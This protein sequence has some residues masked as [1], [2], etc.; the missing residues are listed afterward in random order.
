MLSVVDIHKRFGEVQALDGCSL[1]VARGRMLGFLGPNGA[2]KTTVMRAVFGLVEPDAARCSGTGG[3]SGWQSG[4]GSGTCRRSV[5]STRGCRSASSSRTSDAC[6]GW[7]T[8]AAR[9]AAARW[10]ERLGLG[11]RAGAKVEE[12]SHG[13]QQR[14]QLAAALLHEPELLVLDEPFAGLDPVAVQTLAEVLRGEAA[15]G[16]AVLFSSH[17]LELVEDICE[18]VAI[19]DHGR[20]VATGDVDALS[21]RRSGGGSSSSS[22]ARRRSGCRTSPASSSSSAATATCGCWPAGTSTRSRCLPQPSGRRRSSRSATGRPRSPSS[23]WSWWRRERPARDRRSSPGARSAS[24][25]AARRSSPRRSSCSRSSADRPRFGALSKRA[26]LPRRRDGAGAAGLAAALQRAAQPFDD[27]KVRLR[28]VAVAGSRTARRSRPSRST[29]C[30]SSRDDRLVF[31]DDVDPKAAAV[32]DTAVRALRNHLPPAPEL[33]TATLHPPEQKTTD[34]ATLV[35][36]AGSLLLLMSL[37]VYGQWVI[38]GVVEE[39]NNRV[40]ELILSTVRPRHLL[41]GK[42]IGIGLLGLAQLALVA[43]LAAALL[44][45]GVFD[46]PAELG[47]SIALVIPWFALGFALYAVAYAA[48]G[49]LASRQQNAETAGQP[50]TYTLLAVYFAGYVASRATRTACSRTSSPSSR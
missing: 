22:R 26:D 20:V 37:A 34:A 45:A 12:L 7:T 33:T 13:N 25:C 40:V 8:R 31:R 48:A 39:K 49:A 15:R 30:C 14:A 3:R 47:G 42:V 6:T 5:A 2:G 44:V 46:A 27:A 18:E 24:A 17:Q 32:A 41:A 21:G 29:R 43:G 1:S 9:V 23:S 50:V 4:C 10:L 16:A 36:Y 19:I 38:T 11:E 35:A 28:V